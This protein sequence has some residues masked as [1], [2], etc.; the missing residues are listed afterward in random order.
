MAP[1]HLSLWT[2]ANS[3]V[4]L[5]GQLAFDAAGRMSATEIGEQTTQVLSNIDAVLAQAGLGCGIL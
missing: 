2:E 1:P 3:L 4:F 5:S